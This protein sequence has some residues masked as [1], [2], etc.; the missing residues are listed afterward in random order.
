MA[1]LKITNLG[2]LK[3]GDTFYFEGQKHKAKSLGNKDINNVCCINLET[4]RRVWLDVDTE[5]EVEDGKA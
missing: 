2:W 4:K 1:K 5:V 3:I